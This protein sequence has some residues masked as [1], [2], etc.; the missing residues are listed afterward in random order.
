MPGIDETSV[1]SL[2]TSRTLTDHNGPERHI[3]P[4]RRREG[5]DLVHQAGVEV[6]HAPI[7]TPRASHFCATRWEPAR[8]TPWGPIAHDATLH[9][10]HGVESPSCYRSPCMNA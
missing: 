1:P 5:G 8:R 4:G 2:P 6:R 3:D 7:A 10:Q 9:L